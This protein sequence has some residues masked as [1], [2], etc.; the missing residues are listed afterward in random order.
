VRI[1][2]IFYSIQG[3][4]RLVGM[5]SVFIRTSGCNLRCAWCDTP[6]TS[7]RPEGEPWSLGKILRKVATYPARHVVITGGEPLL[8]P[9]V[10]ELSAA[11][12]Q[13]GAHLTIE[14][15]ATI[16]QPVDCDLI[17]LSP[18]LSHSTPWKRANGRFAQMHERNRLH[19]DVIQKFID[20]YDYQI[21]FVVNRLQDFAE[22]DEILRQLRH[23]D[24]ARVLIMAQGKTRAE[25][26]KKTP[27]I[28]ES[29]KQHGYGFTPRLHIDLFGNRRGT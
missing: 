27:W 8:S 14:T 2:E 29:C 17:S 20:A 26:K 6:Y 1:S 10:V 7:W 5:P 13:Q 4:G 18:K 23:S 12:K 19:I 24:P 15:A 22:I 9:E 16:F 25:L 11:I 21:K 3:E 28:V